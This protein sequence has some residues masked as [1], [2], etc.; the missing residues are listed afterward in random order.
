ME[1]LIYLR[2]SVVEEDNPGVVSYQQQL[3][4]CRDIAKQ[5]AKA[6]P[7]ILVDWG[8]SGGEGL[9]HRRSSY[10]ELRDRIAGGGIRWIVSYDLSRLSRST[11]ETLDL[12]DFAR[13]HGARV[14]VGDLGILDP[15]D[16]VGKFTVTAL[17]GANTLLRD[18][19]SKRAREMVEARKRAGLQIGRPP[20]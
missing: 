19:A 20:Y 2:R 9:E 15:D 18:M 14:H 13:R 17:S 16:P 8:K 4:R 5:H 10:Q 1:T 7:E 12:V 6:E 11:R 3:D